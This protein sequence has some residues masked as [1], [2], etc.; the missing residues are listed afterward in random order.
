MLRQLL[1]WQRY[2][3]VDAWYQSSSR[4]PWTSKLG[5]N[6]T[7]KIQSRRWR[8]KETLYRWH[9]SN[10]W[11]FNGQ[12]LHGSRE[13]KYWLS[14]VKD[15]KSNIQS[16][17]GTTMCR[18]SKQSRIISGVSQGGLSGSSWRISFD[19]KLYSATWRPQGPII[20]WVSPCFISSGWS[21]MLHMMSLPRKAPR[22]TWEV[23]RNP[24]LREQFNYQ[25]HSLP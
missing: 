6:K 14:T 11:P 5:I 25:E 8:L 4:C 10:I 19:G 9:L 20:F 2:Q 23:R 18:H 1:A 3:Q 7:V 17:R 15:G 12:Q 16:C 24:C 21:S 22:V 13:E